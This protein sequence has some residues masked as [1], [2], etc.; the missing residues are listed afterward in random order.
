VRQAYLPAP[1]EPLAVRDVPIPRPAADEVLVRV[2]VATVCART[3]LAIIAGSHPPHDCA[4]SGMLPHDLRIH[5][6]GRGPDSLR[7]WY[8]SD[9]FRHQPFP[10]S[11]GHEAAGTVTE[12]GPAANRPDALVFPDERL[13]PGD[14]VATFNVHGAYGE[15][16]VLPS[17]NVVRLPDHMS[18]EEGS[19]LE[20][21]IAN[22]NCLK[23][24]WSIRAP[25]TVA[26]L[27]QGCQ[28]LMATQVVR[29]LGAEQVI[30]SEPR[31][32]K[33]TLALELGAD[34]A[35]DPLREH[36]VDQVMRRT[37]SRGVDLVV[38]CAG[39]EETIRAAPYLVRRGGMLAQIGALTQPVT[40]DYGYVHF[41]H[42]IVVPSDHFRSFREVAG[43]LR[44]LMEL[45]RERGVRLE[46]LITHRFDL[47][48]INDAFRLLRNGDDGVAKIAIDVRAPSPPP[49]RPRRGA[50]RRPREI[51]WG[52]LG[53]GRVARN[54]FL[55]ALEASAGG[56]LAA[57]GSRDAGKARSVMETF[58]TAGTA[59]RYEDVLADPGVEAVYVSLPNALHLDWILASLAAGKHVLCE[60]PLVLST[61]DLDEVARAAGASG[62]VVME[63]FR[64][65]FHP[66]H[67][68][69][70][71]EELLAAVGAPRAAYTHASFSLVEAGDIRTD[72]R[73]GGG[74]LWDIGCY[75]LSI[76]SWRFGAPAA[77]RSLEHGRGGVD[78]SASV[79]LRWDSGF[80]A[81]AWWSFA[82]VRSQRF[83]LVG[84]RGVLDLFH[85]FWER[86]DAAGRLQVGADVRELTVPVENCFRREIEHFG[87]VVRGE[88]PPA[89]TLDDTRRW[90]AVAER[91]RP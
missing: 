16:A 19:L 79:A 84:E 50:V 60:K 57:L 45:V 32:C 87:A 12:L 91:I 6:D 7:R 46:P 89:L 44:E 54:H 49:A 58:E 29:A 73:L 40:F 14:R 34:V 2:S 10:A 11:M 4:L 18:D 78:W 62:R 8:P 3:D 43:Q 86:G 85:P 64:Y 37:G 52:V 83:T 80:E 76:L 24:C 31:A 67:A 82:A 74:A 28:G 77:V 30:V 47:D 22:F 81:S 1:G 55:P 41:K 27:G 42:F 69:A 56:R 23:R 21:L 15:Y 38:E 17:H 39:A 65:R 33:R 59:G 68:D 20:P 88:S 66:Q 48:G 63:A 53:A 51:G 70:R 36:L 75:C 25:G 13:S 90:L 35:I 71:W 9:G 61:A 5:L 26:I 72:F